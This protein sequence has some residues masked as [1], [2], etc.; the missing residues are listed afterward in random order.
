MDIEIR[1]FWYK[2]IA[3]QF[4]K[5]KIPEWSDT[6]DQYFDQRIPDD[7]NNEDILKFIAYIDSTE[8]Q[9]KDRES[10]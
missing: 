8:S 2:S 9:N 5:S 4:A 1:R 10:T 3:E 6:Y 7:P